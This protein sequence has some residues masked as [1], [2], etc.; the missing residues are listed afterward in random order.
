[1]QNAHDMPPPSE[2]IK[3]PPFSPRRRVYTSERAIVYCQTLENKSSSKPAGFAA[4]LLAGA[5]GALP[6]QPP[7]SSSAA[8]FGAALKPPP[9]PGTIGV[10]AKELE[11]PHPG[12]LAAGLEISGLLCAS[13]GAAAAGAGAAEPHSFPPHASEAP[14]PPK[15]PDV[16]VFVSAGAAGL[17]CV[18][19]KLKTELDA[20]GGV[21]WDG[22]G[23]VVV[24][25]GDERSNRSPM[26]D[27]AG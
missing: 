15:A 17:L 24:L 7:N 4:P 5:V 10:L 14:Q 23:E 25:T 26:A 1:M 8:T 13:A 2:G 11:S 19:D 12:V 22:G 16:A 21:G 20:T 18:E 27:D 9:L 6:A 3:G